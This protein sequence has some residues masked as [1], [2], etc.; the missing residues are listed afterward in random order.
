MGSR[1]LALLLEHIAELTR[2]SEPPHLFC[3]QGRHGRGRAVIQN[4]RIPGPIGRVRG[5][6]S[7]RK[8][9][10]MR[11]SRLAGFHPIL[12]PNGSPSVITVIRPTSP[13]FHWESL[14]LRPIFQARE[15]RLREQPRDS[16]RVQSRDLRLMA[17]PWEFQFPVIMRPHCSLMRFPPPE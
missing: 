2:L 10:G 13:V 1:E 14:G 8:C 4:V 17:Q 11:P 15:K 9:S 6:L 7:V 3:C 12:S 16:D 5:P